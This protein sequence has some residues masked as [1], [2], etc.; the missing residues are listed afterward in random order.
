MDPVFSTAAI[1]PYSNA[2]Y[3]RAMRDYALLLQP[4]DPAAAA[5]W[6]AKAD[7]VSASV[8]QWLWDAQRKQLK[9]HI[10]DLGT[11]CGDAW[12]ST[13]WAC[14]PSKG[15]PFLG[16]KGFDEADVY[17]HGATAV[18]IEAEILNT[19]QQVQAALG[20][21][22]KNVRLAGGNGTIGLTLWPPYPNATMGPQPNK[23]APPL[24]GTWNGFTADGHFMDPL[25][26]QNAGDWCA[27]P[28]SL[29]TDT[30][31]CPATC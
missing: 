29:H 13:G 27:R 19:S 25:H 18:A 11:V 12:G 3:V 31:R 23:S 26:Y 24:P 2:M 4:T 8:M 21:M 14:F 30:C 9:P 6:S 22:R 10:Y 7:T 28:T 16:A 15:S 20:R 17:Y 5:N 1:T